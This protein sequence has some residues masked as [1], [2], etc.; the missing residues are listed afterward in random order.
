MKRMIILISVLILV[1]VAPLQAKL[2]DSW[3]REVKV[4]SGSITIYQPQVESLEGNILKGRAAISYTILEKDSPIF[5]V[6]WFTAK[7]QIDRAERI[8]QYETVEITNTRFPE[9]N[10]KL[11]DE[12]EK[13]ILDGM[14]SWNLQSSLDDLTTALAALDQEQ[15]EASDLK[16]DPPAVIYMDRPALLVTIDGKAVLQ[17]IENSPYQAVAN[18]PYPLFFVAENNVWF[19]NVADKVWYKSSTLDGAWKFDTEPP[20]DLAQMVAKKAEKPEHKGTSSDTAITTENAPAIVVVHKPTELIVSTGKAEFQPLTDDLLAMSNTDSSVFMDVKSQHYFLVMSGRW[21]KASSMTGKWQWISADKLPASFAKIP[22]DSRYGDV[23]SYIA[24]TDE[25]KEALVDAQI[26]QTAA[27]KRGTVDIVVAYDGKPKFESISGTELKFG[28]NCSETVIAAEGKYYLVKDGVWYIADIADGPWVVSDHAPPG[29][30]NVPP[31]S[32]VY[33]T[34]YV[35]VY[36]STPE[37]VYVGYTPG[38]MGSYIY[39][40]TIVYGTGWYY[41]P[42]ISPAFYY[43]R[44]ATWGFSVSYNPWT[45]WGFGMSWSSGP[46]HFGFYNGGGYHNPYWRRGLW[47][48]GGY[49]PS[50]NHVTINN[51][52]INRKNVN[53]FS[54]HNNLYRNSQQRATINNT[55][56]SRSINSANRQEIQNKI[57]AGAIG[58]SAINKNIRNKGAYSTVRSDAGNLKVPSTAAE[59]SK[60]DIRNKAARVDQK[61]IRE[62]AVGG[63]NTGLK[64]NVLADEK[65]NVLRNNNGQWEQ[66]VQGDWRNSDAMSSKQPA[67]A[68]KTQRSGYDKSSPNDRQQF[69][70]E[71][72]SQRKKEFKGRS[73]G[74]KRSGGRSRR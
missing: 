6:A 18:T 48:P 10:T 5:G 72:S 49:R 30:A 4:T 24:G 70:R 29:I 26:P 15:K 7:V 27:V 8:V 9:E 40:P 52:N 37:V 3:P 17:K 65:G 61:D 14:K 62:R 46:F 31:S 22:K 39:G 16:N 59:M 38:Y 55:I 45:G 32:P 58:G 47:G 42:W 35:Y 74:G 57:A 33:H 69:S 2:L 66:R 44:P 21:Y 54:K 64:N 12:F 50:Y 41:S 60:D 34:K 56:D 36:D 11:V 67:A 71:R 53:E 73:G 1:V 25:A 20:V 63:D 23:R 51:V 19:L 68:K 13:A 28:V 43:P